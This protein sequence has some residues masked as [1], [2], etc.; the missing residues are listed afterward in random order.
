V[1]GALQL[2]LGALQVAVFPQG[3]PQAVPDL[4]LLLA[5]TDQGRHLQSLL[6]VRD[7]LVQVAQRVVNSTW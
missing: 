2:R 4:R 1:R 6:E 7:R 3:Q 5:S